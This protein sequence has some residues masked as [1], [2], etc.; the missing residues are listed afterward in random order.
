MREEM[1]GETA[2]LFGESTAG[3]A[4]PT[5]AEFANDSTN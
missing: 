5:S 4:G 2:Q 3:S 1:N